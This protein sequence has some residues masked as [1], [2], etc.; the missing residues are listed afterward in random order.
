MKSKL[1]A[2]TL[3]L[4]ASCLIALGYQMYQIQ[5]NSTFMPTIIRPEFNL[6]NMTLWQIGS[7]Q[8]IDAL[9]SQA[10]L[11][12]A[13][14]HNLT[15]QEF[16]TN[17]TTK[18][19]VLNKSS[20]II[21]DSAWLQSQINNAD[22]QSFLNATAKDI[23][24][25]VVIGEQTSALY[26]AL[27]EAEVYTLPRYENGTARSP[28]R[29]NPLVAGFSLSYILDYDGSHHHVHGHFST[30]AYDNY[31]ILNSIESWRTYPFNRTY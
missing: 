3:F 7:S 23:R 10:Q 5:I 13:T 24:G 8:Q 31:E 12:R 17:F 22:L 6:E 30:G 25:F 28:A 20:I 16:K 4:L 2:I 1:A 11:Y 9:N 27:D 18:E 19:Q 26:L 14:T 29:H 21:F 15:I